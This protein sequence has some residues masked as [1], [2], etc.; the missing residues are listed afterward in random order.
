[1]RHL[2]AIEMYNM[3]SLFVSCLTSFN[4]FSSVVHKMED[5]HDNVM[6]HPYCSM[7]AS[8]IYN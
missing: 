1:M 2:K 7:L 8:D 4:R 3:D 5:N 6:Q